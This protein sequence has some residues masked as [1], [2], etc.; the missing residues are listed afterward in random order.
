MVLKLSPFCE[1]HTLLCTQ[2]S[3]LEQ[4]GCTMGGSEGRREREGEEEREEG[5]RKERER[6]KERRERRRG[7]KCL[8]GRG[9]LVTLAAANVSHHWYTG[10][11][12]PCCRRSTTGVQLTHT[13]DI[14]V[15]GGMDFPGNKLTV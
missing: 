8:R 7:R 2:T 12:D 3:I 5:E 6:E 4:L 14:T 9:V 15:E 10:R 1:C 11:S 13:V